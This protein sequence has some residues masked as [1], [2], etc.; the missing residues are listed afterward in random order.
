MKSLFISGLLLIVGLLAATY[1]VAGDAFVLGE[2]YIN[3]LTMLAAVAIIVIVTFVVLK[4]VNQIK[5]DKADGELVED[6]WDNIGEYNNKIPSGWAFSL[7]ATTIWALWYF[8]IGYPYNQFSQIGQWNEEVLEHREKFQDK[9]AN[10][11]E[12]GLIA[13]GESVYLIQCAPCHGV[14]GEGINNK[15]QNLVTRMSEEQVLD[16][17]NNGQSKLNY[18]M[19]A[20]PGG[21]ASGDAANKIAKWIADGSKG[22]PPSEFAACAS[23]HGQDGK[24]M[25]G[26]SP[27]LTAYSDTLVK[28]VLDSGKKGIIGEMPSFKSRLNDTQIKAVSAYIRSLGE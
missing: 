16:V 6:S 7:L 5:N 4:Y 10:I 2:D 22:T 27:D 28:I 1:F 12:D 8:F 25:N 17:I 24:G 13:M 21:M 15:A 23:C 26:M 20:M 9:H 11:T 14:D 18:P 19:G 3:D